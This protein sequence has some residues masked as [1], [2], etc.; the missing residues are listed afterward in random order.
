MKKILFILILVG[1]GAFAYRVQLESLYCRLTGGNEGL[2]L[3][4]TYVEQLPS[5]DHSQPFALRFVD[6]TTAYMLHDGKVIGNPV[7]YSVSGNLV[8]I[9]HACG[10]WEMQIRRGGLYHLER[11]H[12]FMKQEG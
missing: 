11:R 5:Y 6:G 1:L 4:G 9:K 7:T 2:L 3:H 10:V 12:L 8:T